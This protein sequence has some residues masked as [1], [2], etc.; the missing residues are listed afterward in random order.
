MSQTLEFEALP[1][2]KATSSVRTTSG[3]VLHRTIF[4]SDE[5]VCSVHPELGIL[6][7]DSSPPNPNPNP[8]MHL[9]RQLVITGHKPS[10]YYSV[11]FE[12]FGGSKFD[13]DVT[14]APQF[15]A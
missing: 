3:P 2:E 6:D 7:S 10:P 4:L 1:P 15:I 12:A 14:K 5:S 8:E 11:D 13:R 9:A